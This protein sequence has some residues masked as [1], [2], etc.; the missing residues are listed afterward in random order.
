MH[1]FA[2]FISMI[3]LAALSAPPRPAMLRESALPLAGK[4]VLLVAPRTT[5]ASAMK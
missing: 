2:T 3:T 1:V 4:R 5:A